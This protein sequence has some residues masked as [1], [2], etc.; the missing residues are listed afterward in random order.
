MK[1]TFE[2]GMKRLDTINSALEQ[3]T[4]HLEDI[5]SF[6]KEGME[7]T[8][9]LTKALDMTEKEILIMEGGAGLDE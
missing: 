4:V 8:K 3:D 5:L 6:Y 1:Y 9:E 7:I 2:E